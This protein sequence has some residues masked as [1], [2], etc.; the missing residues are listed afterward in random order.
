MEIT[1]KRKDN[2]LGGFYRKSV[3]HFVAY[4]APSASMGGRQRDLKTVW[5]QTMITFSHWL[6]GWNLGK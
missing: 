5:L 3:K 1:G 2:H 4:R 6:L